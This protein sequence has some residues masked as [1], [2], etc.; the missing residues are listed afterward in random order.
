MI[1]STLPNDGWF[2]G[3]GISSV[4]LMLESRL[5]SVSPFS[6]IEVCGASFIKPGKV[7]LVGPCE[8]FKRSKIHEAD[9]NC[10]VYE[11]RGIGAGELGSSLLRLFSGHGCKSVATGE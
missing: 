2:G 10:G 6:P 1:F 8:F 4:S 5:S 11:G 9:E 7:E 3:R